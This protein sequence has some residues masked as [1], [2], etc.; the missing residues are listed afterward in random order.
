MTWSRSIVVPAVVLL[1]L[2]GQSA[3]LR[4]A[5]EPAAA[6][7]Y[8]RSFFLL[9]LDHHTTDKMQVGR[10]AD[11][12]ATARLIN[13]VKPDVIQIHA[14]GNPG[15][16]TYPTAIGFTPPKL[17][18]DVMQVWT[19][20]ARQNGYVFSAYYNI[21]RDRE[22]MRRHPEWNRVRADG[23]PLDNMLCYHSGVAE[24]YLWPMVDEIM[25]RYRPG[26][27]WFDGSCFTVHNCYCAKCRERFRRE[28]QL[29]APTSAKQPGW[30][31][32]KEM[33]RQIY[34]EFCQE[35]AARIKRRD[36]A[37]LVAINWAWSLRMPEEPP[38]GVDYFT[39]D[40]GAEI[41][42]L[43]P[44]AIW[45]D[46]QRRPFD[47]MT[48]I[49][50]LDARGPHLK[51]A[52]QLEQ[53]LAIIIAHGGRYF[54][55]DNPTAESGL[56]APRYEMLG[57]VVSPFLRSRQP[58]CLGSRRLPDVAVFHGAAAHYAQ[59]ANNPVAFPRRNP[60]VLAACEGLRRLH[61]NPELISDRRLDQ[62]DIQG[63]LL[64][65][66]DALVLTEANRGALRRFA[67]RG[68]RILLTGHSIAAAGLVDAPPPD[69][70]GPTR[71][72]LG[73]G[74]VL[75]RAQPLFP[76][77]ADAPA[78]LAA[79]QKTLRECL[80]AAQRRVTTDAPPTVEL[81]LRDKD[82]QTILHLV[83]IA[84]GQRERDAQALAFVNLHITELPPTPA[85]RVSLQC[86]QRPQSVTLQP[87]AQPLPDWTWRDGRL[88]FTVPT[89]ATHQMVVVSP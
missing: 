74:E 70:P 30:A 11:P 64:L 40:H 3:A 62:G 2:L 79:A 24:A 55:W 72:T 7:W 75:C 14:K 44:D 83:N 51:S 25:E 85:C 10:D 9:H 69:A 32:Y 23:Q 48:T 76:E 20:V 63:R 57:R 66:E 68:G 31:E 59:T 77:T 50:Y 89:F 27:F 54:A 5:D 15:W 4:A 58:W 61:L 29:V 8:T 21:G 84:P 81:V 41:D 78:A 86:A 42:G 52:C 56:I 46:S 53:E 65:V 16:T 43:A 36:P 1:P 80:P 22:I 35:T 87:Q 45:Y 19:D 82:G 17:A 39:G 12:A 67:E 49:F 6:N 47:L 37:C 38:P 34:R 71:R 88:E 18:R 73:Q 60:P 33:Q 28:R 26:G 13:L